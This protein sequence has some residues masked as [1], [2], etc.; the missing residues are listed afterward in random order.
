MQRN[1][2][3]ALKESLQAHPFFFIP[4]YIFLATLLL[5]FS[6]RPYEYNINALV[7]VWDG[8]IKLNQPYVQRGLVIFKDGGYDGQF[9]YFISR[10]LYSPELTTLPVLDSFYLR[11]NRIGFPLIS[12]FFVN[13]FGF[14][15]YSWVTFIILNAMH[16]FSYSAIRSLCANDRKKLSLF[17]LF[18]PFA[19]NSSLLLVSDSFMVSFGV[20]GIYFL[21]RSGFGFFSDET[22]EKNRSA[23]VISVFLLLIAIFIRETALFVLFPVVVSLF[24]RKYFLGSALFCIPILLYFAFTLGLRSIPDIYPGTNPL[25]FTDLM[26]YPFFGFFKSFDWRS[27]EGIAGLGKEAVKVPI[28]LFF[29]IL[30]LNIL[31]IQTFRD[32]LLFSPALFILLQVL[33]AE[34]GYWRSFD[35]ISRMFTLAVPVLIFLKNRDQGYNDFLLLPFSSGILILLIIRIILIK[36]PMSYYIF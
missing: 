13:F 18:S 20:L 17:Y 30:A 34:E 10:F 5:F 29:I 8:F 35:N 24:I 33:V 12:G 16:I 23:L 22:Q 32:L 15:F 31:N 6:I 28:F 4:G 27:A 19:L 26:D 3:Y 11:F 36:Q 7:G 9:F 14:K 21:E 1:T 2:F 25:G